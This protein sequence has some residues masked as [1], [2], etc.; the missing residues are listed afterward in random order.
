MIDLGGVQI[1]LERI[2][3]P[4]YLAATIVAW[5]LSLLLWDN[6]G[7]L[8]PKKRYRVVVRSSSD[9]AALWEERSAGTAASDLAAEWA[10]QIQRIGIDDFLFKK[11][12]GWR[13]D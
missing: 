11:Q 1:I 5:P 8:A 2:G 4:G 13:I 6:S 10:E 9:G 12:H 7:S 3:R